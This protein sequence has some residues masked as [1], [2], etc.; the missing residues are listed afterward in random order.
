[1]NDK[2]TVK[3]F[4]KDMEAILD[5]MKEVAAKAGITEQSEDRAA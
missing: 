1:M 2:A 3:A 4:I 5:K